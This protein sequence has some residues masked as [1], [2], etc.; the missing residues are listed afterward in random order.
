MAS[1]ITSSPATGE[2]KTQN[3][4]KR[5]LM[6][7][8]LLEAAI[9]GN[10]TDLKQLLGLNDEEDHPPH[11]KVSVEDITPMKPSDCLRSATG[12]GDT[13]LHILSENGCV[14]L[15]STICTKDSSLLE[16]RNVRK[17]TPFHQAARFGHD[18]ILRI[19]IEHA[20]KLGDSELKELLRQ[21]N[22]LGE[23]A[24]HEAARHGH[25]AVVSTLMEED[26]ELAGLVNEGFVSP[27]YLATARGSLDIVH[28]MVHN[29]VTK[30]RNHEITPAF[31]SGPKKQTAL[32]A[33]VLQVPELT[34]ELLQLYS[35]PLGKGADETGRT[36]LHFIASTGNHDMAT[37]LLD[38]D[39]SLAYIQDSDG[40]FPVHTAVRMGHRKMI[41]LLLQRCLDSGQLL[42]H[43]GRNFLH[44]ALEANKLFVIFKLLKD[45][46]NKLPISPW[47]KMFNRMANTMDNKGN[48]PLHLAAEYVSF[49]ELMKSLLTKNK[50]DLTLQNKE[51]LTAFDISV[52]QC[53]T[54]SGTN[55][56][57]IYT[58]KME[59]RS[60]TG[61][62]QYYTN[63]K[64]SE[65]KLRAQFEDDNPTMDESEAKRIS[66][67]VIAKAQL[68][69]LGSVLIATVTFAAAFT[70]PG[71]TNQ[72]T[73][74][75]ILGRKYVFKAFVL[76]DFAAFFLSIMS[77]LM[78]VHCSSDKNPYRM[79]SY[80]GFSLS[81]F[82]IATRCMVMALALGLYVLLAPIGKT[83]IL[84]LVMASCLIIISNQV[85]ALRSGKDL[86]W[87]ELLDGIE[88]GDSGYQS[89]ESRVKARLQDGRIVFRLFHAL[90]T[91]PL[92]LML[93]LFYGVFLPIVGPLIFIFVFAL[94]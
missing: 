78:L 22:C 51:G 21:Q 60:S 14:N 34:K 66:E 90:M 4:P 27:L 57:K 50:L 32:H 86:F 88:A 26:L 44:I 39:P 43:N 63:H 54:K 11:T 69:G 49:D 47:K 53:D 17:E 24:L 10:E 92:K 75:P 20:K 81:I 2:P 89:R 7:Y 65:S 71:G 83:G 70:L 42:D 6:P 62:F 87:E 8:K 23:T 19:L 38:K 41:V 28:N 12:M 84:V 37:L 82:S 91:T 18:N 16:A 40:S 93:K 59:G 73:G 48:T 79:E 85:T 33:A 31:Y 72:D 56:R 25:G 13:I 64:I 9:D 30:L 35:E 29:M 68:V 3:E 36:P 58:S 15:V 80:V 74:N 52:I 67:S 76:A 55:F 5:P 46:K 61:W 1:K 45:S 94:V 77:T